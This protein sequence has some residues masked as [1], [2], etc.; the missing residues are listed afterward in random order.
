MSKK[1]KPTEPTAPEELSE[2]T[3]EQ[4]LDALTAEFLGNVDAL[5]K[6]YSRAIGTSWHGITPAPRL[7]HAR[8]VRV[9]FQA[10]L[11]K[12]AVGADLADLPRQAYGLRP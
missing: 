8:Q 5:G 10:G 9:M 6:R 7:S 11:R 2:L 3:I 12:P 1:T 4:D